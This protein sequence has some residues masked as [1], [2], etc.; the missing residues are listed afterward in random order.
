MQ[1]Y[2]T[3]FDFASGKI[4][5]EDTSKIFDKS[6]LIITDYIRG[7]QFDSVSDADYDLLINTL[8]YYNCACILIK[9]P[10]NQ[11]F[12]YQTVD[13]LEQLNREKLK[14]KKLELETLFVSNIPIDKEKVVDSFFVC[15]E[16]PKYKARIIER[17]EI[18]DDMDIREFPIKYKEQALKN[19]DNFY[20][21]MNYIPNKG[22]KKI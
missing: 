4:T 11:I 14:R 9:F 2:Q 13:S 5:I 21:N 6:K 20:K 16:S 3:V 8:T 12:L 18:E 19:F 10:E 17:E 15:L 7:I 22:N 1:L